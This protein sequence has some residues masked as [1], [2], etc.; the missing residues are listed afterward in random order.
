MRT[1]GISAWDLCSFQM[2][3]QN[4]IALRISDERKNKD[5]QMKPEWSA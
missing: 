1:Q 5:K 3:N 4:L 2:L